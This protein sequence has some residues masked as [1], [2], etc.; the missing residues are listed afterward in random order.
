[1]DNLIKTVEK[2]LEFSDAKLDELAEKNQ[3]LREQGKETD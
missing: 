3:E 2:F 1:M